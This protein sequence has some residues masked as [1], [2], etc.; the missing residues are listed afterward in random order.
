MQGGTTLGPQAQGHRGVGLYAR[1]TVVA[2]GFPFRIF[3]II[4]SVQGELAP[5]EWYA[6]LQQ[7]IDDSTDEFISA[8]VDSMRK[9]LR[10][11]PLPK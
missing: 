5:E 9:D 1:Q 4:T 2:H 3:Q 7:R 11:P 6:A 10:L 8:L